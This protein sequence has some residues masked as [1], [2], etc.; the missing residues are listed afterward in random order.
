M[1]KA[2]EAK[3][4]EEHGDLVIAKIAGKEFAFKTPT[5]TDFETLVNAISQGKA[6]LGPLMREFCLKSVVHPEPGGIEAL[7]AA[8]AA[9]PA[10]ALTVG[11]ALQELAGADSEVV[12]KKA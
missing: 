4:R 7:E 1:D 12:V 2:R 5:Q 11:N 8:F 3:L 10:S 9:Q 6:K